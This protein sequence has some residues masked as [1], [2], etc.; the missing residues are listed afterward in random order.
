MRFG[1][2]ASL[3]FRRATPNCY[4]QKTEKIKLALCFTEKEK[5]ENEDFCELLK[6]FDNFFP[7][8]FFVNS[9][10]FF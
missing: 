3:D 10:I 6:I 4:G 9:Q 7:S 1:R 8:H 5:V 2:T